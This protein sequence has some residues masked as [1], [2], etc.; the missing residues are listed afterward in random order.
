MKKIGKTKK[1]SSGLTSHE[2]SVLNEKLDFLVQRV[3]MAS[4]LADLKKEVRE[5]EKKWEER[6]KLILEAFD[7]QSKMLIEM[8]MMD[9][10]I[11][12]QLTRHETWIKQIAEKTGIKLQ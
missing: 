6:F 8:Q 9:S 3:A 12:I 10:G 2:F 11:N 5:M 7:K 1:K 4:E